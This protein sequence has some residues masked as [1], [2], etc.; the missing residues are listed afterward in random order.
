MKLNVKEIA[1][2]GIL[3]ALMFATKV[4]MEALPNIHLVG[5]LVVAMTVVFRQK[6]LYPVYVFV[7]LD[8]ILHASIW[9]LPNLYAWLLLW[10]MVMLLP[11]VLSPVWAAPLYMTVCGIHGLLFGI[12]CA[13]VLVI[14]FGWGFWETVVAGLPFDAIHGVSNFVLGLLIC[15]LIR[16][17]QNAK[18]ITNA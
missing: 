18:K 5:V 10:G 6:A 3:G 16:I 17:L 1:L 7:L 11:K 15:P 12:L 14:G 2:F 13:P 8:G 9:W 4:L